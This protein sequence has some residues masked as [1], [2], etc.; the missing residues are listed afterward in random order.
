MC[1]YCAHKMFV[2]IQAHLHKRTQ[3]DDAHLLVLAR[4]SPSAGARLIAR[5]HDAFHAANTYTTQSNTMHIPACVYVQSTTVHANLLYMKDHERRGGEIVCAVYT[6]KRVR[7]TRSVAFTCAPVNVRFFW[8][9]RT[10]HTYTHT[11]THTYIRAFVCRNN[12]SNAARTTVSCATCSRAAGD[13]FIDRY[14]LCRCIYLYRH[15]Y[16]TLFMFVHYCTTKNMHTVIYVY[17]CT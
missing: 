17:V 15:I 4:L 16:N 11:H 6:R 14:I 5:T 3:S 2:H 8:H 1:V 13:E 12:I 7:S 10:T 9:T